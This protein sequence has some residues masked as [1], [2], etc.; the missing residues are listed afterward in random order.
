MD[1]ESA[2]VEVTSESPTSETQQASSSKA[3]RSP[4]IIL[5]S[6]INLIQ[7]QRPIRDIVKGDLEFRNTRSGT[8]I[9]TKE[10]EDFLTIRKYLEGK[11]LSYF[12]FF[13][14]SEKLIVVSR[15]P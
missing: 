2:H 10:M 5:T 7:L 6:K 9:I 15:R 11:N 13:H 8:R 14:K 12:T 1:L 3:G 4:P